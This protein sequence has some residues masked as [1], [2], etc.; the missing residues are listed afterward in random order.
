M[1]LDSEAVRASE[2]DM[3]RLMLEEPRLIRRPILV[4]PERTIFGATPKDAAGLT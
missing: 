3:V 1:K 4:T 2:A